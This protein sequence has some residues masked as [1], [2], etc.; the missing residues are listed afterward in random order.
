MA[1]T[2]NYHHEGHEVHEGRKSA[3]MEKDFQS[4]HQEKWFIWLERT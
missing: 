1:A 4:P 2:K 3:V